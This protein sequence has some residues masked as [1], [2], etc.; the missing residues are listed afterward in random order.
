[1]VILILFGVGHCVD[2]NYISETSISARC[3]FIF[4]VNKYPGFI[5]FSNIPGDFENV[6]FIQ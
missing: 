2:V 3:Q 1:M 4:W 5:A 6:T